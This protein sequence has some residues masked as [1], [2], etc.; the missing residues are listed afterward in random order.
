MDDPL[1]LIDG[2]RLKAAIESVGLTVNKAA[3]RI[4]EKQQTLNSIVQRQTRRCRRSR[5]AKLAELLG[6]PFTEEWLGGETVT[7]PGL[8]PWLALQHSDSLPPIV[9]DMN[10]FTRR[11]SESGDVIYAAGG[12]PPRYEIATHALYSNIKKAWER[13]MQLGADG[14]VEAFEWLGEGKWA[15]HE[16]DRLLTALQFL[17]S[18]FWWRRFLQRPLKYDV[19]QAATINPEG[20][21]DEEVRRSAE[22]L[23]GTVA[24]PAWDHHA[25]S[26]TAAD[27]LGTA[28]VTALN[29]ALG[30]W[31]EGRAKLDFDAFGR[32]L[33]WG[34]HGLS[35]LKQREK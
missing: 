22:A 23:K 30:L 15:G 16:W 18:V 32:L 2:T 4:G 9:A 19:L 6:Y 13:D 1:V 24:D 28:G 29:T 10:L 3:K 25:E 5:R 33:R 26:R 31:Y 7:L 8:P 35:A 14:A 12:L 27:E 21:W 34:L 20:D 17:L 11:I